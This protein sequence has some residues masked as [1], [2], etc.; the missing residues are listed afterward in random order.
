MGAL[1]IPQPSGAQPPNDVTGSDQLKQVMQRMAMMSKMFAPAA[2]LGVQGA[3]GPQQVSPAIVG[4]LPGQSPTMPQLPGM[5]GQSSQPNMTSLSTTGPRPPMQSPMTGGPYE[6]QTRAGMR[7]A[8]TTNA[9]NSLAGFA[10]Q[11]KQ[12]AW[13]KQASQAE[14]LW[15]SYNALTQAASDAQDPK[16]KQAIQQQIQAMFDPATPEGKK[17]S[18]LLEKAHS[19]PTS[20]AG[21]GLQRA[22]QMSKQEA[23]QQAQLEEQLQKIQTQRA[24]QA[25][26]QARAQ[27]EA[28]HAK[29]YQTQAAKEGQVTPAL[30]AKQQGA[31]NR[32]KMQMQQRA[33][34]VQT[35]A[36]TAISVARI[37]ADALTKSASIRTP[38][39]NKVADS[40]SKEYDSLAKQ[41]KNLAS[42]AKD[43]QGSLD[44]HWDIT[45]WFTDEGK[46]KGEQ[47][48]GLQTQMV[49]LQKQMD[50]LQQ[51][52]QMA[53][54]YG[55]LPPEP[56][57]QDDTGAS[58]SPDQP[59]IVDPEDMEK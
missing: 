11:L 20:A 10:G 6:F 26:E 24:Q 34:A 12:K 14:Q 1:P 43:I 40:F 17:N 13:Q 39:Q 31:S 41:Y 51:K 32:I 42:Q 33:N 45:N 47:L 37:R 57:A 53:L 48:K 46:K 38:Q 19:D 18:K 35:Q 55:A 59:I 9:I 36:K 44:K 16:Q 15:S 30:A 22:M 5:P 4:Q 54:Q 29:L 25:A 49:T 28:A 23:M 52:H 3:S 50:Q 2:G 7:A 58:G 27:Q 56:T 21:V 8:V